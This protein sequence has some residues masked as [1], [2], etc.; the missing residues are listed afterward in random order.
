LLLWLLEEVA[1]GISDADAMPAA[2]IVPFE[3][4]GS[5]H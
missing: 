4:E 2:D 1:F 5:C 3:E